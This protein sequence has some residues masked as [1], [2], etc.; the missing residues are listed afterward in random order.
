MLRA[1]FLTG[2]EFR[3]MDVRRERPEGIFHLVLCRNLVFTYYDEALQRELLPPIAEVVVPGG[4]LV[5]G[6]HE[7]L[8]AEQTHFTPWGSVPGVYRRVAA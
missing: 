1:E 3:R 2:V 8:P 4:A 6:A 5:V 7:R